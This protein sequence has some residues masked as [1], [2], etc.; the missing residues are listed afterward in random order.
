MELLTRTFV[1][2]ITSPEGR[3]SI[4]KLAERMVMS[5]CTGVG[6]STAHA[7]TT[8]S[9]TES[10]DVRVMTRKSMDDPGRPPGIVLSAATSF[11]IP[12]AAKGVFSILRDENSR[13]EVEFCLL[14][15]FLSL[16]PQELTN[17]SLL[18]KYSTHNREFTVGYSVKWWLSSGNGSHC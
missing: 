10:A 14:L 11:R 9:A 16:Q 1:T 18:L 5:F 8:L 2:V 15:F 4:L 17:H 12:V 13:S 6:A 7:W 3:K